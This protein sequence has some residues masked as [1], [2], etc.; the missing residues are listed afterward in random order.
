M[1]NVKMQKVDLC[2]IQDNELAQVFL[3][4]E[5]KPA[6]ATVVV[7]DQIVPPNSPEVSDLHRA[8]REKAEKEKIPFYYGK[9][10]CGKLLADGLLKPGQR[11]VACDKAAGAAGAVGTQVSCAN[12]TQLKQVLETGELL[13]EEPENG[14][15]KEAVKLTGK[16]PEGLSAKDLALNLVKELGAE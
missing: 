9:G 5:K 14:N 7:V 12:A 2:V 13:L 11:A 4:T 1:G 15:L 8:L 10:M 16:L 6:I 3:K